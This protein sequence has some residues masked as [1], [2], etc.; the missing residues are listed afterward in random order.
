MNCTNGDESCNTLRTVINYEW[1]REMQVAKDIM[2]E[3]VDAFQAIADKLEINIGAGWLAA[4]DK[5]LANRLYKDDTEETVWRGRLAW[6]DDQRGE[7]DTRRQEI[8]A[9]CDRPIDTRLIRELIS[10]RIQGILD[11]IVEK[12][13]PGRAK[14][15]LDEEAERWDDI[16]SLE[17]MGENIRNSHVLAMRIDNTRIE[18]DK[19]ARV[20]RNTAEWLLS[21]GLLDPQHLPDGIA[22][23]IK[24]AHEM[25]SGR[26]KG[27][28][29][30]TDELVIC[31]SA[32]AESHT[33]YISRL[34]KACD[35]DP[36]SMHILWCPVAGSATM[37]SQKSN[38]EVKANDDQH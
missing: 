9:M 26:G 23:I 34:L 24:S 7:L 3:E 32:G 38:E 12:T 33:R 22:G 30:L 35:I 13:A 28:R 20:L 16:P 36:L 1:D 11:D 29:V 25:A 14:H 17:S 15:V 5:A 31:S 10:G 37:L 2:Q 19:W 6:L 21:K 18:V 8:R 4:A 27:F